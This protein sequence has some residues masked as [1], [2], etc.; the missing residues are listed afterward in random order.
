[1]WTPEQVKSVLRTAEANLSIYAIHT[2]K[3]MIRKVYEDKKA[4]RLAQ[5]II[6]D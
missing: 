1:M 4:L 6:I 5:N 2:M 3:R